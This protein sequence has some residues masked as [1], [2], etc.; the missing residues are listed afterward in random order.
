M[1]KLEIGGGQVLGSPSSVSPL[2]LQIPPTTQGY[3][4][5]QV[6][7]YGLPGVKR[8][9]DYP[10]RPGVALRVVARFS[11]GEG[12]LL[13]T[14]GFGFWNAPFGDPTVRGVARPSACWF[15]YGSAPNDLPL[16]ADG[17]GR[18]W[19]AATL[20]AARPSAIPLIPLAPFVLLAN[21]VGRVRRR[22]W[23][24]VQARLG[25]AFAPLAVDMTA[26]H[27]YRLAWQPE[28]CTFMVDGRTLLHTPYS[29]R[30]PLGFV[31]WI[32]NQYMVATGDGRFGW[33]TL[34]T[35]EW[36]WLEVRELSV[37]RNP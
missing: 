33:G 20:D 36:Q 16:A 5:A 10:W 35:P 3:T 15:F 14:A 2:R 12:G 24:W 6:D 31:C 17:P 13:G 26:W 8:R 1:R 4:D 27:E 25:I 21:R 32:D 23:P 37:V 9:A 22:L 28:G 18:G 19:F 7:D 29:P 34:V 30:G 11:H